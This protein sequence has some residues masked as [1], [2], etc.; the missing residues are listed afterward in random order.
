MLC[1]G[2]EAGDATTTELTADGGD[3]EG[4]YEMFIPDA[5]HTIPY[6]GGGGQ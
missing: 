6:H 2:G 3:T 1:G 4:L 5:D